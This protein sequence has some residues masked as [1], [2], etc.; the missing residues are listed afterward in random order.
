MP[1]ETSMEKSG[2]D[3]Y[4]LDRDGGSFKA[5]VFYEPYFY[6]DLKDQRRI[7]ELMSHLQKRF[8]GCKVEQAEKE[9]LDMPNHLS[10]KKHKFLKLS[11]RTVSELMDAKNSLRFVWLVK[12]FYHPLM[13]LLHT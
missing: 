6:V 9:D 12:Y 5:T 1:D 4:F 13:L 10:G 3:L 8:E 2:L 11:F 7:M